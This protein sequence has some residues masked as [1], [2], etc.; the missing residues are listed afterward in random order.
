MW[1]RYPM[2]E[3]PA[4]GTD[5]NSAQT[6]ALSL[7]RLNHY[8]FA[9]PEPSP[10]FVLSTIRFA[11]PGC[12]RY[13]VVINLVQNLVQLRAERTPSFPLLSSVCH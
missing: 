13:S 9:M 12:V 7:M 2:S 3:L 6:V 1:C 8:I 5:G 4:L 11:E 10:V